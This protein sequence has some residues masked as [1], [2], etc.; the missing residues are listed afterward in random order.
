[1]N[2]R[3]AATRL[4]SNVACLSGIQQLAIHGDFHF[5][6]RRATLA[7]D[8]NSRRGNI[9]DALVRIHTCVVVQPATRR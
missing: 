4:Q 7:M 1:M 8:I 3:I 9:P 2:R 5:G 6:T